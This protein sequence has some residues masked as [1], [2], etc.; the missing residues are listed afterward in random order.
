MYTEVAPVLPGKISP[1]HKIVL[2][3]LCQK[4]Q[5]LKGSLSRDFQLQVF[6]MNQFPPTQT[7]FMVL[8][9]KEIHFHTRICLLWNHSSLHIWGL[10]IPDMFFT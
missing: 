10:N 7:P 5:P 8:V 3:G 1:V 9:N 2:Q 4:L 6:F